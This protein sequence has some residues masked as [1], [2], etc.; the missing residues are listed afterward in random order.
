MTPESPGASI[1][2]LFQAQGGIDREIEKVIDYYRVADESLRREIQEYEVTDAIARNL[3]TFL[4]SYERTVA[5]EI[6]RAH[7]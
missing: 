6:G 7:V 1:R 5:G 2:T 3:R 4:D